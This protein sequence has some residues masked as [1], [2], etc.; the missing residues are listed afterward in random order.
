MDEIN[1]EQLSNTGRRRT[2]AHVRIYW[3]KHELVTL[4]CACTACPV[5]AAVMKA[6]I[7]PC[8]QQGE[9][10]DITSEFFSAPQLR[11]PRAE[12][13]D[14]F[15]PFFLTTEREREGEREKS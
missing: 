13:E 6:D 2:H 3:A 7:R 12:E 8:L 5:F 1:I 15:S 11:T 10:G 4:Q 9:A 14:S